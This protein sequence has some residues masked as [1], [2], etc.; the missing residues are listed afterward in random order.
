MHELFKP[1]SKGKRDLVQ[2]VVHG[3]FRATGGQLPESHLPR[4][5]QSLINLAGVSDCAVKG[6]TGERIEE[7]FTD[8]DLV[9]TDSFE[10]MQQAKELMRDIVKA[11]TVQNIWGI[12]GRSI[13]KM[14]VSSGVRGYAINSEN[15]EMQ[16]RVSDGIKGGSRHDNTWKAPRGEKAQLSFINDHVG[17][18][19]RRITSAAKRDFLELRRKIGVWHIEDR[20]KWPEYGLT[21][22]IVAK[23]LMASGIDKV[24]P[25]KILSTMTPLAKELIQNLVD[26]ETDNL[27]FGDDLVEARGQKVYAKFMRKNKAKIK[28]QNTRAELKLVYRSTIDRIKGVT[29]EAARTLHNDPERIQ[30]C[31][32]TLKERRMGDLGR[33][34]NDDLSV[35]E[36]TLINYSAALDDIELDKKRYGIKTAGVPDFLRENFY[37]II[38]DA[39]FRPIALVLAN[40]HE[41]L[42]ANRR[43]KR[44]F[45]GNKQKRN[46]L[47]NLLREISDTLALALDLRRKEKELTLD[48]E[49]S[50]MLLKLSNIMNNEDSPLITD[51]ITPLT[52]KDLDDKAKGRLN[53]AAVIIKAL[54]KK[55]GEEIDASILLEIIKSGSDEQ[56]K[57]TEME[58]VATTKVDP[59]TKKLIKG[60]INITGKKDSISSWVAQDKQ[61]VMVSQ[62]KVYEGGR[63]LTQQE[64]DAKAKTDPKLHAQIMRITSNREDNFMC[65]SLFSGI[66]SVSGAD[67]TQKDM[68]IFEAA[69]G[70][71]NLATKNA[72]Q[73]EKLDKLLKQ[74]RDGMYIDQITEILNRKYFEEVFPG[75]FTEAQMQGMKFS[76]LMADLDGLKPFDDRD[77]LAG[78]FIL[79][80]IGRFMREFIEKKK[81]E[82]PEKYKN[83]K[84]AR[85]GGDEF[86][87]WLPGIGIEESNKFALELQ[88]YIANQDVVLTEGRLAGT[89]RFSLSIGVAV[90]KPGMKSHRELIH[91]A[92]RAMFWRKRKG[93]NGV[94]VWTH[95]IEKEANEIEE[96][97]N[98]AKAR[99]AEKAVEKK[100]SALT[101]KQL[102]L[103]REKAEEEQQIEEALHIMDDIVRLMISATDFDRDL[104]E[105]DEG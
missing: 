70:I 104:A 39:N 11:A 41:E 71:I 47:I 33:V 85:Y 26:M 84:L 7:I 72:Q 46:L 67:L 28:D 38:S 103:K 90:N 62:G 27:Y 93:K 50:R 52:V 91:Q 80:E 8:N 74:A 79:K 58:I 54:F 105:V 42:I 77:H 4:F 10:V 5:S 97:E 53:R 99:A 25:K 96:R 32:E 100:E 21:R 82:D 30:L 14:G 12:V 31:R 49:Q 13:T 60:I 15:G 61:S 66:A 76:F 55:N 17:G 2:E 68:N 19:C 22:E 73:A 23:S 1:I 65:L 102:L 6:I 36:R 44:L 64:I 43:S 95:G 88:E 51:E 87:L 9:Y 86:A 16:C 45:E 57:P 3:V 48:K 69:T 92:D 40:D 24:R 59:E 94:C 81:E 75:N 56:D 83:A 37:Y 34:V 78:D 63:Q 18:I 89:H 35:F 20:E 101:I 29:K 98:E